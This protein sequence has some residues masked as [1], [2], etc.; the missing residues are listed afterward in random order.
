MVDSLFFDT[1]ALLELQGAA[2]QTHFTISSETLKEIEAIKTSGKKDEE[3]KYRA[4]QIGHLLDE[5]IGEFDV[6]F[7]TMQTLDVLTN[8][9]LE[10]T[11]DNIIAANAYIKSL[12]CD[13]CFVTNDINLKLVARNI[14]KLNN[15]V[16]SD[17]IATTFNPATYTGFVSVTANNDDELADIY[18]RLSTDDFGCVENQYLIIN[19][20]KDGK[21]DYDAYRR[22]GEQF[23]KVCKVTIKSTMFGDKIVAKDSYQACAINSILNNTMTAITGFPGSGKSLISLVTA[24][25]LIEKGKYDRIVILFNPA[26]ALGG[27]I[28]DMGFYAGSA[29]DKAMSNAIGNMLISKLGDRFAVDMLLTQDKIRLVSMADVRG[30]EIR[31]NEI[32]YITEAQNTNIEA[33]KLCLSRCSAGC[34]IIIEGDYKTQVDSWACA[35]KNN[36]LRRVIE[37]L[38]GDADFGYVDLPNVWRSKIAQLVSKL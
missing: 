7:T 26:K 16:G 24:F 32:L 1:N 18:D 11:A 15:V 38:K 12:N 10:A 8:M 28:A 23:E 2:F 3:T 33:I 6:M 27:A 22:V 34:K 37:A 36:G 4:R 30:M 13:V 19:F 35:G 25:S 5:H 29:T 31:D 9:G 20:T 17:V 21:D 14:F